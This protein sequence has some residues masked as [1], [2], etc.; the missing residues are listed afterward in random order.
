[1]A[2]TPVARP[3]PAPKQQVAFAQTQALGAADPA[4]P[5]LA[6]AVPATAAPAVPEAQAAPD[7]PVAQS[8]Q[9]LPG[10]PMAPQPMAAR[11]PAPRLREDA[12]DAPAA[13]P[14][15]DRKW[16]LLAVGGVVLLS[17]LLLAIGLLS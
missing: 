17:V 12:D 6:R 11:A 16:L 13:L 5:A 15:N 1:M 14:M 7:E 8:Q 10:D 3:A 4:A 2:A 9:Y